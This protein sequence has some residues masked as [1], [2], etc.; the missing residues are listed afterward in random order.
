[1]DETKWRQDNAGLD[2]DRG[3]LDVN[4]KDNY[5]KYLLGIARLNAEDEQRAKQ[6]DLERML[7]A[8]AENQ[9]NQS[10][11]QQ[12]AQANQAAQISAMQQL[13]AM[14]DAAYQQQ[15]ANWQATGQN[16]TQSDAQWL[17]WIKAGGAVGADAPAHIQQIARQYQA[18]QVKP[19]APSRAYSGTRISGRQ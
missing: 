14:R 1:M 19:P 4:R 2:T 8:A 12:M 11:M 16:A 6:S 9:R 3:N 17:N 10:Y 18:G 15:M 13:G 5:A 7:N